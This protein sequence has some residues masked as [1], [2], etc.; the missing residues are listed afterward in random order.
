MVVETRLELPA[1][2]PVDD[3][4]A[5]EL[6]ARIDGKAKPLGALGRLED[7][8]LRLGLI[9]GS[10]APRLDRATLLLFAGDHGLVAEGVAAY[11]ASVTAEM[12]KTMLRGRAT[13]NAFAATVG[14]ELVV[15][16]AG[17]AAD[18]GAHPKLVAE[19]IR[20]GTANAARFP[21]LGPED[22]RRALSAGARLA[23]NA[24]AKGADAVLLGDMGIGNTSSAALVTHRL[25]PAALDLC[26][27]P[28]AGHD[29]AGLARKREA[30]ER[31]AARTPASDP[32]AVLCEFGGCEIAMMAGAVI[33]A[34]SA[35]RPVLVDG[36][37]TA[38]AAL[39][40]IR[41]VPEALPYCVFGHRSPE[42]GH[43]VI[44]DALGAEPLLDLG[45]RLGEGTGALLALP[46][47][48]AASRIFTDVDDLAEVL[49]RAG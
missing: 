47:L 3:R 41:L 22:T 13:A 15:I 42:P 48:R 49:A 45:L 35:R 21:A 7:L 11:P 24:V 32:F 19:K 27:G 37:I 38:S 14:A 43:R 36:F 44:L 9:Q 20:S 18:L 30:I 5:P 29:A 16:D 34:A 23:R 4:L 46:L 26:I 39:A 12:V 10:L 25:A 17:V 6:R 8:A 31:A 33:G 40:A 2:L 28:G 1:V